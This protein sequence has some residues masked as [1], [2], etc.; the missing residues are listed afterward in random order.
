[1]HFNGYY[2]KDLNII[3]RPIKQ[4]LLID[5]SPGSALK[6]PKNLI[7]IKPWNGEKNDNVLLDLITILEKIAFEHDIV[8]SYIDIIKSGNFDGIGTF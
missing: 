6:N 7:R 2:V 3:N 1:M 5:D 4:I 8:R